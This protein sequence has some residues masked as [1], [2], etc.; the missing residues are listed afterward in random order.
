VTAHLESGVEVTLPQGVGFRFCDCA[1]Y[2]QL[3]GR[4]LKEMDF[5]WWDEGRGKLVLLE[6]K[7]SGSAG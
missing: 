2:K 7:T 6:P 4:H 5:G 3:S 1:T